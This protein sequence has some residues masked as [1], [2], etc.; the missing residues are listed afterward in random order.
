MAVPNELFIPRQG[1]RL[2]PYGVGGADAWMSILERR[3]TARGIAVKLSTHML[4]RS[5][6]TLLERTL[7]RS[8]RASRD[9]VYRVVQDFLRDENVGTTMR[10]LEPDPSRQAA[11]MQ[12][13]AAALL[14]GLNGNGADGRAQRS[15]HRSRMASTRTPVVRAK[16]AT[17]PT[18]D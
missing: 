5:G 11:A 1:D 7:L 14:W 12:A 17:Q 8:P 13:L 4:R 18:S 3:L 9:G 15:S 2:I 6:A 10:Y 16:P